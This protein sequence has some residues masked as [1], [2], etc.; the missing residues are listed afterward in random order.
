M[1]TSTLARTFLASSVNV[2]PASV[3][4]TPPLPRSN[5]STPDGLGERRLGDVEARRG[6]PEMPLLGDREE[7]AQQPKLDGVR[8]RG[9]AERLPVTFDSIPWALL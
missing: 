1:A 3:N 9:F 5:S 2:T 6:S 8:G 4:A 7:V